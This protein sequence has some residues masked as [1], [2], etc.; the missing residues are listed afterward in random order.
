MSVFVSGAAGAMGGEMLE[1]I[2]EMARGRIWL[3][4]TKNDDRERETEERSRRQRSHA[5]TEASEESR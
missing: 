4:G 3:G 2:L 1:G 5:D